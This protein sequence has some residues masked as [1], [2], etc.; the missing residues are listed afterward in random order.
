MNVHTFEIAVNIPY[1]EAHACKDAF[2]RSA[3]GKKSYCY[4]NHKTGILYYQR[5]SGQ[6][7][8]VSLQKPTNNYNRKMILRVNPSKLLGDAEAT[9]L[10][11]PTNS[12]MEDLVQA[13]DAIVREIPISQT[14]HDFKLNRLDL[15]QNT[16]TNNAVLLEYIRLLEKGASCTGWKPVTYSDKRASH[17][18]RRENDRYQVT[19]YDKLYQISDQLLS[20]SWDNPFSLLRMEA[21]LF[22]Q[23][24]DQQLQQL[25]LNRYHPWY[26]LM[27]A[28]CYHGEKIML[29][30]FNRLVPDS[31]YYTLAKA[32]ERIFQ[33]SDFPSSKK[34]KLIEF[35]EKINRYAQLDTNS[36]LQFKN[37]KK[38]LKQLRTLG[39]NPVTIEARAG[40]SC[41]PSL[42]QLISMGFVPPTDDPAM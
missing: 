27:D 36:I 13:L 23:G 19:V 38:R 11:A 14:I 17:S 7:V 42:P 9:A 6:G 33:D 31:P 10:F 2:Y 35:L 40:I 22:S 37:G 4:K 16:P 32:K 39:I 5:W 18:F 8:Q 34:W 12:N 1:E 3:I 26:I 20:T 28:L 25:S 15:C 21:S 24:I 41:L 30:L 29:R